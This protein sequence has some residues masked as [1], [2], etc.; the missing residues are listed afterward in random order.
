MNQIRCM[1]ALMMCALLTSAVRICTA[2]T[3]TCPAGDVACLIAAI[4]TT[5]STPEPDTIQLA[6]GRYLLTAVDNTTGGA[7]RMG[8]P[9]LLVP[10]PSKGRGLTGLSLNGRP[11]RHSSA[12]SMSRRLAISP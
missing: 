12:S 1:L 7:G 3:F 10:S 11:A 6:A 9:R 4:H 5:N 2:A 8:C